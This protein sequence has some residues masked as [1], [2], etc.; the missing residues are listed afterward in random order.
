MNEFD[1]PAARKRFSLDQAM[2]IAE[3]GRELLKDS[4]S[5]AVLGL[6]SDLYKADTV[7]SS[8]DST[9]EV[10]GVTTLDFSA[11]PEEIRRYIEVYGGIDTLYFHIGSSPINTFTFS[12]DIILGAHTQS[13]KIYSINKDDISPAVATLNETPLE[14][15]QE[16]IHK[17][18]L[19]ASL[20]SHTYKLL[21]SHAIVN[22]L[23]SIDLSSATTLSLLSESLHRQAK[24]SVVRKTYGLPAVDATTDMF[25]LTVEEESDQKRILF[26]GKEYGNDES[27]V[28]YLDYTIDQLQMNLPGNSDPLLFGLT[29]STSY[30]MKDGETPHKQAPPDESVLEYALL[31]INALRQNIA[32]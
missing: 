2:I 12:I 11:Y 22:G 27:P 26:S 23:S 1:T 10:D 17:L 21:E 24:R 6:E 19:A 15:D 18:I 25:S 31:R 4:Y 13:P 28:D 3:S 8:I 20:P 7:P 16:T 14:L 9:F 30:T 5:T 29:V 32:K